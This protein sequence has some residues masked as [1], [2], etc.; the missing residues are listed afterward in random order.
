MN[1]TV[2]FCTW[3]CDHGR[4][5]H[6]FAKNAKDDV[7]IGFLLEVEEVEQVAD[8]GAVGWGVEAD[9]HIVSWVRQIVA[10]PA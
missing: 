5:R 4:A 3:I 10:A 7:R 6:P 2:H 8:G 1:S 9:R